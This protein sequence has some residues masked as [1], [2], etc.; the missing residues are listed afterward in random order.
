VNAVLGSFKSAS[1]IAWRSLT[2]TKLQNA[3]VILITMAPFVF[4]TYITTSAESQK[5]T[6]QEQI[7]Y[8]LGGAQALISPEVSPG[9]DWH[10]GPSIAALT[11]LPEGSAGTYPDPPKD[12]GIRTDPKPLF[13]NYEIIKLR[14]SDS[15]W[16]TKSGVGQILTIEGEY[17]SHK[18]ASEKFAKIIEGR[19]PKTKNEVML[20]ESA[21]ERFGVSVGQEISQISS[22]A[23]ATNEYPTYKYKV[24]GVL[25]TAKYPNFDVVFIPSATPADGGKGS[26]EQFYLFGDQPITWD[27]VGE[28]NK[29]GIAVLS[30]D[31]LANPP[32]Y[33]DQPL[34]TINQPNLT[35]EDLANQASGYGSGSWGWL[36]IWLYY[37]LMILVPMAVIVS[38]AFM[39]SARRQTHALAILSSVGATKQTIQAVTFISAFV[40]TLSGAI[41]GISVGLGLVAIF[42]PINAKGDWNNYAGFHVD[43][44]WT[45]ALIGLAVALAL[46]VGAIPA[47]QGSKTNVLSVL[48]GTNLPTRLKIKTGVVSLLMLGTAVSYMIGFTIWQRYVLENEVWPSGDTLQWLTITGLFSQILLMLGFVTG[49][50]WVIKL[51]SLVLSSLAKLFHSFTLQFAARDLILSRRRFSPLVAAVAVVSFMA[52]AAVTNLYA[53]ALWNASF[54]QSVTLANQVFVDG[55]QTITKYVKNSVES[56]YGIESVKRT[57]DQIRD[58][59]VELAESS[60]IVKS[61]G[62]IGKTVD[63]Y[64]GLGAELALVPMAHLD[65]SDY[66]YWWN[67]EQNAS[68][69]GRFQQS[70]SAPP[71]CENDPVEATKF[72]VGDTEDLRLISGG[73]LN[74]DV[75]KVLIEGGFVA[76]DSLYV[77]DGQVTLDWVER[78]ALFNST[79][80]GPP[81]PETERSISLKGIM[82][83]VIKGHA[84]AYTGMISPAT[85]A[86]LGIAYEENLIVLNTSESVPT[87]LIDRWMASG[88]SPTYNYSSGFTPEQV[89]FFG[90]LVMLGLL[91]L[92]SGMAVGL[93][94][95]E[96]RNDQRILARLG[97][98]RRFL[99]FAPA[100]QIFALLAASTGLG[101][102]GGIVATR[103]IYGGMANYSID[104]PWQYL[105]ALIVGAPLIIAGLALVATPRH[106]ERKAKVAIE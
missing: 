1:K 11:W 68:Y 3:L 18:F 25:K 17:W 10:Q 30:K 4:A 63:P 101:A 15:T 99:R 71:A 9:E 70:P 77:K 64:S 37:A 104:A 92:I 83:P 54:S 36:I 21:L 5:A 48:R 90:N 16:V 24:V 46:M 45:V 7:D 59:Q 100:V 74:S 31:V 65:K 82:N 47:R 88:I 23:S 89:I 102:L 42:A 61:S 44:A 98:S 78:E 97:A 81:L 50:G 34:L 13:P 52:T 51:V 66:C 40:L 19:A 85:A 32:S 55:S 79:V 96:A 73:A 33:L 103:T 2:R 69:P 106:P 12:D 76:F 87:S 84:F 14:N 56:S 57:P 86:S 41:L 94:Q 20:S 39:F 27:R 6:V 29:L 60:K 53:S 38:A 35:E 49:S 75:E 91:L 62:V 67:K 72:V 43:G 58:L 28:L 8:Q 95:I 93:T 26:Q 105:L 80:E 22:T